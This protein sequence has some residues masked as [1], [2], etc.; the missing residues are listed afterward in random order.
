[1][2][3]APFAT[4]ILLIGYR[5]APTTRKVIESLRP[6]QPKILFFAVNGPNPAV[7]G[8][9]EQ[10][11]AVR[12]LTSEIDWECRIHRL[13][14]NEHLAAPESISGAITWFFNNVEE[15]I[16]LE[17]D[18]V[19]DS[20]FFFF[21]E[22][23]LEKYRD[24]P[25]IMQIG[26]TNFV[27][28]VFSGPASYCFSTYAYIWGWA[29][30]RRAWST[31]DLGLNSLTHDSLESILKSR[32]SRPEDISYWRALYQYLKSGN[33]S[34]WDGQWN[35]TVFRQQGLSIVPREN[36]VHNIG[37]GAQ[38]TNTTALTASIAQMQVGKLQWPLI[39]PE[40]F[41]A[42]SVSDDAVSD[43]VFGIQR[44][45]W[46]FHLKMRIA[47]RL[48]PRVKGKLKQVLGW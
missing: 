35:L 15:G 3:P 41:V 46:T 24:N 4:P 38:S 25:K 42:D 7:S 48:S 22:E 44:S 33:L 31:F 36:L 45:Y 12:D 11:Q 13:F 18:C 30:W 28:Q 37:F 17:D 2:A 43:N 20:S 14:R 5:R 10:C 16:I 9:E 1:M 34:T 27:P 23:L 47:S 29:T 8:E 39:H 40:H 6:I 32:F 21:A 26:A 19:C